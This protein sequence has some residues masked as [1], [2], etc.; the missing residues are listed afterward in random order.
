MKKEAIRPYFFNIRSTVFEAFPDEI[1][2]ILLTDAFFR[3]ADEHRRQFFPLFAERFAE[4][5]DAAFGLGFR[6]FVGF[7]EDDAERDAVFAEHLDEPQVDALR[8]EPDIDQHEQKM[9]PFASE[10]VVRDDLREAVARGFRG[11]GVTVPGQVDQIPSVIDLEMIDQPCLAGH[12]RDLGQSVA[13]GQQVDERRFA[14]VAPT[15]ERDIGQRI[16]RQL[17][18]PLR[19][20]FELD[21]SNLHGG[22]FVDAGA[23]I[24]SSIRVR[25]YLARAGALG[26]YSSGRIEF[27]VKIGKMSRSAKGIRSFSCNRQDYTASCR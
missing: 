27:A 14:Y 26:A 24:F 18:D 4:A 1:E 15:D 12:T 2:Y 23:S 16:V 8:F 21:V 5:G 17:G 9:K 19:G 20:A 6:E 25:V 7:R 10:N 22:C 13:A 3:G 11:A